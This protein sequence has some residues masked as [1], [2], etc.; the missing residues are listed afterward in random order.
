MS[1]AWRRCYLETLV[2]TEIAGD[3]EFM[4]DFEHCECSA[5]LRW[6][7]IMVLISEI[8][9]RRLCTFLPR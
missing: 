8:D 5:S 1:L 4:E 6:S 3:F 7:F 2:S 9:V